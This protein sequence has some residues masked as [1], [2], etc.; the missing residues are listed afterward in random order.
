MSSSLSSSPI[1]DRFLLFLIFIRGTREAV[2]RPRKIN[3]VTTLRRQLRRRVLLTDLTSLRNRENE[4]NTAAQRVKSRRAARFS[5]TS[6]PRLLTTIFRC[7][8]YYY[9]HFLLSLCVDFLFF[10]SF[11]LHYFSG[12]REVRRGRRTK[13]RRGIGRAR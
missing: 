5:I 7:Y 8:Y 6:A 10:S 12:G 13:G 1:Y 3:A 2:S 11:F 4:A 9:Y